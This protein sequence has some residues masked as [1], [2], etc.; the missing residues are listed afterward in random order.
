VTFG[1]GLWPENDHWETR[2][3]RYHFIRLDPPRQ[4]NRGRL[5]LAV[6]QDEEQGY[7]PGLPGGLQKTLEFPLQ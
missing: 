3:E 1:G 2:A 7:F 6:R 4:L 5:V